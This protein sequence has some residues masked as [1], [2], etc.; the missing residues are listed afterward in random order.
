MRRQGRWR[1]GEGEWTDIWTG[2]ERGAGFKGVG[3]DGCGLQCGRKSCSWNRSEVE[4]EGTERDGLLKAME[5]E[6]AISEVR[7]GGSK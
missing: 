6:L 4:S 1:G 2:R 7:V 3:A 5:R